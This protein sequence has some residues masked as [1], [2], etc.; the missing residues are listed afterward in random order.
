VTFEQDAQN[1]YY[2]VNEKEITEGIAAFLR[3]LNI[4]LPGG[5]A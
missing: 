1:R 2:S 4:S 5:S 3:D